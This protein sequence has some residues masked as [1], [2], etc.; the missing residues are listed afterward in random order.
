MKDERQIT[1]SRQLNR[2]NIDSDKTVLSAP[3][4]G[5]SPLTMI[6][7]LGEVS[8]YCFTI[9]VLLRFPIN[10]FHFPGSLTLGE[11]YP[12]NRR[13]FIPLI[14]VHSL[15]S[16]LIGRPSSGCIK[17]PNGLKSEGSLPRVIV[18]NSEVPICQFAHTSMAA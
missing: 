7:T 4:G 14:L 6:Q 15:C 11:S 3:S 9:F 12:S 1:E 17:S 18:W 5:C 8:P 2:T 10:P 13:H 16:R